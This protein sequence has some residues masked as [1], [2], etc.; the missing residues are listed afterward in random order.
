MGSVFSF[1][2]PG[3]LKIRLETIIERTGRSRTDHILDALSEK[4]KGMEDRY[5]AE[6]CPQVIR[7]EPL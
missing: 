6:E 2:L 4:L 5:L 7:S 1:R 3:D